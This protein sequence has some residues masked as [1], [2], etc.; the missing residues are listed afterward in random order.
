MCFTSL[1]RSSTSVFNPFSVNSLAA[2]P[3]L[4]PEPIT[5]ASKLRSFTDPF[6]LSP[7]SLS[8]FYLMIAV[9]WNRRNHF[10]LHNIHQ[11]VFRSGITLD[12][13]CF[14]D[15]VKGKN[16]QCKWLFVLNALK[17]LFLLFVGTCYE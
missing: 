7:M 2:Q 11:Y 4:I 13:S 14:H 9:I 3:P 5:I 6:L 10:I 16:L 12:S 15:L 1:P 8:V 17:Y